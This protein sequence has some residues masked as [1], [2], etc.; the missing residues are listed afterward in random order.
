MSQTIQGK[1]NRKLMSVNEQFWIL[2][3]RPNIF[4][5]QE[6]ELVG[7]QVDSLVPELFNGSNFEAPFTKARLCSVPEA[8]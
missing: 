5:L 6:L 7:A 2:E 4:Y 1:F 8:K 3:D